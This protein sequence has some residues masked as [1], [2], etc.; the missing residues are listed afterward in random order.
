MDVKEKLALNRIRNDTE[1]HIVVEQAKCA[2]CALRPCMSIC[3]GSLYEKNGETGEITI[4]F[5]G[6]LECGSCLIACPLGAIT[7]RYPGGKFG[8]QYRYG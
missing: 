7:W 1:S 8:V 2:K 6:C 5:S 3:P 4:E